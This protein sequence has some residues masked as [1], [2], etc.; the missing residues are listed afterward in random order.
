MKSRTT[1]KVY[2]ALSGSFDTELMTTD[3]EK[4]KQGLSNVYDKLSGIDLFDTLEGQV[5]IKNKQ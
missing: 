3:C 4:F 5:K 1:N 2:S